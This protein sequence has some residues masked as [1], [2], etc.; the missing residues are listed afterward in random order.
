[1]GMKFWFRRE[2]AFLVRP[3]E[4]RGLEKQRKTIHANDIEVSVP[5]FVPADWTE[6]FAG[7]QGLVVA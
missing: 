7:T 4:L 3:A 5:D 6:E 1:M 2:I